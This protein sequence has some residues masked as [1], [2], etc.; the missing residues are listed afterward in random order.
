MPHIVSH[1]APPQLESNNFENWQFLMCSHVRSTST[2]LWRI[3]KE[4]YSPRD[5]RNLTIRDV[6]DD[7][8]NA[9]AIHMIHMAVT[10]KDRAHIRFLKTAK[11]AWDK[12][13]KLFLVNASIQRS[14]FDEVDN[15][16]DNVVMIEEN[17]PKRYIDAS[18][19]SP[20]KC[21]ILEQ[22]LWMTIG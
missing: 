10:P 9:T 17:L 16:A 21:K 2:E 19:L 18:L 1:G 5:P 7:Q 14:R 13:D 3:I 12:L 11:E 22:I 6:V 8:L 4:G 15:M 20:W